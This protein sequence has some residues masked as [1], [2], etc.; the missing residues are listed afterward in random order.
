[1][2]ASRIFV[3]TVLVVFAAAAAV[4]IR[5]SNQPQT[6]IRMLAYV[7]YDEPDFIHPL[8]KAIGANIVVDTYVGGDEMYTKFTKSPKGTYDIV[9][10]DAEYGKKLFYE[11]RIAALDPSLWKFDDLFQKFKDGEPARLDNSVY[12]IPARWDR[13]GSFSTPPKSPVGRSHPITFYSILN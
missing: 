4:I 8:E 11:K 13:S 3:I 1:M 2:R 7:G 10:L 5:G 9:V 12:A 6:A